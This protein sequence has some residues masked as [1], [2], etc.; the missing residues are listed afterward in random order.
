MAIRT[1]ESGYGTILKTTVHSVDS[2]FRAILKSNPEIRE[3]I[4]VSLE[5]ILHDT[6]R[7]KGWDGGLNIVDWKA[8]FEVTVLQETLEDKE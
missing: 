3:K 4:L 8:N 5:D 2:E 7:D 6:L 1:T